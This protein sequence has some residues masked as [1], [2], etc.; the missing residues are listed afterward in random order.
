MPPASDEAL[1]ALPMRTAARV[2]GRR[3][4]AVLMAALGSE[5]AAEVMHHLREEEIETLSLEMVKMGP[6][7]EETTEAILGELAAISADGLG[8]IA[9]G[10]ELARE[11][12]ERAL[13]A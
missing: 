7:D 12:L 5:R 13:G 9:G 6:I 1:A 8:G 2:A 3:R 11:G 10:I 4:P